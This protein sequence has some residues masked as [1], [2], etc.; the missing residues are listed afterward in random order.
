MMVWSAGKEVFKRV[1]EGH[2]VR[3]C[4]PDGVPGGFFL[5]VCCK[6]HGNSRGVVHGGNVSQ[7]LVGWNVPRGIECVWGGACS[8]VPGVYFPMVHFMMGVLH[9]MAPG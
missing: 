8:G 5:L 1:M 2:M 4:L 7:M 3:L 9:G 6:L